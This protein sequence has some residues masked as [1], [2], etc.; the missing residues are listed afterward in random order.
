M[1][2]KVEDFKYTGSSIN[3]NGEAALITQGDGKFMSSDLE[4]QKGDSGLGKII[5]R[6]WQTRDGQSTVAAVTENK[7][8]N[9]NTGLFSTLLSQKSVINVPESGYLSLSG[10]MHEKPA[11]TADSRMGMRAWELEVVGRCRDSV[12]CSPFCTLHVCVRVRY[13]F[14]CLT[15]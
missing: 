15:K 10:R 9:N 4:V 13:F 8:T 12:H 5:Y 11:T 14:Y 1:D 7:Q 6:G 2:Y 3:N